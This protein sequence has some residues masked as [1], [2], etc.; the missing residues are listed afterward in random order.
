MNSKWFVFVCSFILT[1]FQNCVHRHHKK[2][3]AKAIG[4]LLPLTSNSSLTSVSWTHFVQIIIFIYLSV[5]VFKAWRSSTWFEFVCY[6]ILNFS[7]IV[8]PHA[9]SRFLTSCVS[10]F[11]KLKWA[12]YIR[13]HVFLR[14]KLFFNRHWP[15]YIH[16]SDWL[17]TIEHILKSPI[18]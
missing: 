13:I 16:N 11:L 15:H 2:M 7:S 3:A 5:V 1:F 4:I 17:Q 12:P 14:I 9:F 10:W 18:F 8:C 6:F